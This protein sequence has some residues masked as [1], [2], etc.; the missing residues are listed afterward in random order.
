MQKRN[1]DKLKNAMM[2]LENAIKYSRSGEFQ[3]LGIEFKSVLISAVVQN[4]GLTF[5]VCRQMMEQQLA[6]RLGKKAVEEGSTDALFRLAVKVGVITN[7]GRWLEYMDCEHLTQS[8]NI[9]L[10]TFE[11]ASAFLDDAGELLQTCV[12]REQNERR[13]AA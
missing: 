3:E 1:S 2:S 12:K 9:A 8:S 5:A 6:D 11:K 4:F 10:R 7:L 13:R